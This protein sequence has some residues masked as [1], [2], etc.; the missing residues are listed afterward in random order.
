MKPEKLNAKELEIHRPKMLHETETRLA[1]VEK[2][3]E[4]NYEM[5][6]F[7]E[8]GL[9]NCRSSEIMI[10]ALNKLGV[11]SNYYGVDID[12]VM[13]D[14]AKRKS[15]G[16]RPSEHWNKICAN[17]SGP[18]RHKFIK[19]SS[20]EIHHTFDNNN[21]VWCLIDGCHCYDCCISDINAYAPKIVSG[22]FLLI[23]DTNLKASSTQKSQHYH[24]INNCR[25]FGVV[26]GI[27][28][29]TFLHENF[30]LFYNHTK[31]HGMQVW[32]RN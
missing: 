7:I 14:W 3:L 29:A 20:H 22:G 24:D 2:A 13:W 11:D 30:D 6:T 16:W 23:H 32:R 8:I 28:D 12:D 27:K 18:C 25:K 17:S 5:P 15:Y 19:G 4:L 26:E 9:F 31:G 21:I 10:N 1:I